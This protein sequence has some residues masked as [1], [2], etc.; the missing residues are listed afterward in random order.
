MEV[1]WKMAGRCES[2]S[3]WLLFGDEDGD[4]SVIIADGSFGIGGG[5][6]RMMM[7]AE[8]YFGSY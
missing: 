5:G 1:T 3:F 6:R 8:G 7:A 2:L 4:V